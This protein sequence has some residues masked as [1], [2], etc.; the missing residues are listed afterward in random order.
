MT[1][2][3]VAREESEAQDRLARRFRCVAFAA[4]S[5]G[6]PLEELQKGLQ[7]AVDAETRRRDAI[8]APRLQVVPNPVD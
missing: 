8:P 1:A 5:A 4:L 3:Q 6:V 2:R 7:V